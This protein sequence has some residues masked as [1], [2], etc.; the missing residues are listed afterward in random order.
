MIPHP[1]GPFTSEELVEYVGYQRETA[2]RR[3][4][5]RPPHG[6][7]TPEELRE[8]MGHQYVTIL[9]HEKDSYWP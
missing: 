4:Q 3:S 1:K 7:Y 5:I 6:D 8:Y 9:R 2:L